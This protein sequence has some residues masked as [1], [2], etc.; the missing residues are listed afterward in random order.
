[1]TA[2]LLTIN[3]IP[4]IK[5][6]LFIGHLDLRN[7]LNGFYNQS[8]SHVS[9]D[10]LTLPTSTLFTESDAITPFVSSL[11]THESCLIT[12]KDLL[13]PV[14][15]HARKVPPK[16][17]DHLNST[18]RDLVLEVI[19]QEFSNFFD[20]S[21]FHACERRSGERDIPG[22]FII[23]KKRTAGGEWKYKARWIVRGDLQREGEFDNTF[24]LAGDY[25]SYRLL[26]ALAASATS[27]ITALDI[28]VSFLSAMID[29]SSGVVQLPTFFF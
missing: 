24:A 6:L 7:L 12:G 16:L 21:T 18:D 17:R 26:M 14:A 10:D 19:A 4:G 5:Q 9:I 25:A 15:E 2:M 27:T 23:N 8:T 28:A 20:S 3:L 22:I 29:K 1:M 11:I 13:D